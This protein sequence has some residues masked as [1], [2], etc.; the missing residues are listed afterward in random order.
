MVT[1]KGPEPTAVSA[2]GAMP[3]AL[4]EDVR[5]RVVQVVDDF[6]QSDRFFKM[7]VGI[8]AAWVVLSLAT[9]YGSCSAPGAHSN[10]LGAEV[11]LNRDSLLG[12]QLL[13]RNESDHIWEDVVITLDDGFKYTHATMRPHDLV[14]LSMSSFTKGGES[15]PRDYKPRTLKVTC[16]RGSHQFDLR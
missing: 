8:V 2:L 3:K 7:R 15:P 9:L 5:D 1:R 4:V 10:R 11:Q 13:I 16:D 14:V 12:V 6:K